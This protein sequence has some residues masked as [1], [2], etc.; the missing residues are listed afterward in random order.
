MK[1]LS[2]ILISLLLLSCNNNN[3]AGVDMSDDKWDIDTDYV[4]QGCSAG[5]DCIPSLEQPEHSLVSD[6]IMDY[7]YDF[8][9]VVGVWNGSEYVA[10]PHPILDW[11]EIVNEDGYTISYCPLTGSAIHFTSSSEFGV[12]GLLYNNNLIMYDR[13]TNSYWPQMLLK[14][15][16]GNRRGKK[17]Q[18]EPLLETTWENWRK[19]F[20]DSKVVNTNTGYNRNYHHYPYG[21]YKTCN[22]SDCGDFIY[23]PLTKLDNRLPAKDRVLAIF[24]SGNVLAFPITNF[25]STIIIST[26]IEG[27]NYQIVISGEDNIA[28][29]F[30]T[31]RSLEIANWDL[32]NGNA[33]LKQSGSDNSWNLLGQPIS[34]ASDELD[35]ATSY[36]AYWFALAAFYPSVDIYQE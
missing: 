3:I 19:L 5:Q 10:Y 21:R 16:S 2:V 29:A 35:V 36:I 23:F 24:D 33:N 18:L 1:Q 15:A 32:E 26:S 27:T 6:E 8:D 17:L 20:P 7:L 34:G 28:V 12:S 22:S 9:L 25:N 31:D 13:D 30:E 11:H 14:S 4:R